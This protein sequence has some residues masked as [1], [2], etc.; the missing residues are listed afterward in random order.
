VNLV[1]KRFLQGAGFG[2]VRMRCF[3]GHADSIDKKLLLSG[4][5]YQRHHYQRNDIPALKPVAAF[6]PA[7][8]SQD[9]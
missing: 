3:A 8:Q 6:P 4:V 7:Q 9:E 1:G 2:S 5:A